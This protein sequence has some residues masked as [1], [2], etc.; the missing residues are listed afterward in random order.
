MTRKA[1]DI[2]IGHAEVVAR[3]DKSLT[4]GISPAER[5]H[6]YFALTEDLMDDLNDGLK[7]IVKNTFGM[8]D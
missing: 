3:R 2:I 7:S 4:E 8:K 1:P 6:A 5:D